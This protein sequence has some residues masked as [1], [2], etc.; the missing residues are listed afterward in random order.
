MNHNKCVGWRNVGPRTCRGFIGCLLGLVLTAG[1]FGC[2]SHRQALTHI[3]ALHRHLNTHGCFTGRL[4]LS[5]KPTSVHAGQ[6][7]AVRDNGPP[8]SWAI[9]G[10]S[11]GLFGIVQNDRFTALYYVAAINHRGNP[12]KNPNI[13]VTPSVGMAGI[14]TPNQPFYVEVPHVSTGAYQMRFS[15]AV[16]LAGAEATAVQPGDHTLC[17]LLS[18]H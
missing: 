6:L 15:Y 17:A 12:Q 14:G 13:Q 16:S 3:A 18:V 10:N 7:I 9:T 8:G 1:S 11:Y 5:V 4:R 2:T